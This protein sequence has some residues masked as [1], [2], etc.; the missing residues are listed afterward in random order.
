M[1]KLK[2]FSLIPGVVDTG[3]KP[4]LLN[5]SVNFHKTLKWTQ[6]DTKG[7]GETDS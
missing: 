3:D 4:L 1:K 7:G 5:I 2:I 6:W